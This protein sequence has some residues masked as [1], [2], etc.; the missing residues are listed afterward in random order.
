MLRAP[1][2]PADL[3]ALH[4]RYA[5][6]LGTHETVGAEGLGVVE[7]VGPEVER[8][9]VGDCVLPLSRGNWCRHRLVAEADLVVVPKGVAPEQAAML[10]INPLTALLLLD[11]AGARPGDTILQ[12]AAGS[13]VASWVRFLAA[14]R[15][16]A[17]IDVVRRPAPD[18][19]LAIVD[20]PDLESRVVATNF[21]KPIQ[22]ALDCVAGE[23]T[24]R[25]AAC[26]APGGRLVVFG[27]LSGSP[28]SIRSQVM[29][30]RGL[31]I[32]GFS[33]RPAEAALGPS[34]VMRAFDEI[35][36]L[37]GSGA[38]QIPVRNTYPLAQI[39]TALAAAEEGGSGR[40]MLDLTA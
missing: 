24:G 35:F 14:R 21:G 32:V 12:N 23:A 20:G 10:R 27:H 25:L 17:V 30:G 33:L 26:L 39:R 29:T 36:A 18:L 37:L 5:F 3:Q 4:G 8:V 2:N 19:P 6:S 22:F 31:S 16:I 11:A 34:A 1:I 40:V 13:A 38:P 28:I 7:A 15:G 9:A